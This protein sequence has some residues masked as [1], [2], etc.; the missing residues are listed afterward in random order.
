MPVSSRP[1]GA[2]SNDGEADSERHSDLYRNAGLK[3]LQIYKMV[4][5]YIMTGFNLQ[6]L[7]SFVFVLFP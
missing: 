2:W 6:G 7:T 5:R 1:H 4:Y 3:L